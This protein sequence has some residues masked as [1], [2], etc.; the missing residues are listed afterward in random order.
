MRHYLIL[1][2]LASLALGFVLRF[3][4]ATLTFGRFLSDTSTL[5][6]YQN[7]ITPPRFSMLAL[8]VYALCLLG[9][10]Y[11]FWQF[12][13]LAG[14][15][16][17]AGFFFAVIINMVL[18]LPKKNSE[19]F[20]KFILRSMINRYADYLKSGDTLRASA[21]AMLLEK[22]GIPVNDFIGRNKN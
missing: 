10:I 7:A 14:F 15:G 16:I 1:M 9:I 3:T 6:G 21:M 19:H 13:W 2:Y 20:R 12:G 18:L 22:A 11:G 4:A 5:T 17:G 8:S